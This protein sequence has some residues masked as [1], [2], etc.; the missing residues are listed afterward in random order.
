MIGYFGSTLALNLLLII[1]AGNDLT[2]DH[3]RFY[4]IKT[5]FYFYLMEIVDDAIDLLLLTPSLY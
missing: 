3:S 5:N 1:I 2:S 4:I